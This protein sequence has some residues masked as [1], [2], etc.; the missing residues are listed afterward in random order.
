MDLCVNALFKMGRTRSLRTWFL[1]D[2]VHA[3]HRLPAI[4]HG[5]QTGR[6]FGGAFVLGMH[7]FDK[8]EETYG[9]NGATNL[10]S[11]AGTKLILKT[12]DP[13]TSRRCSEFIGDR[14]VR[15]MDEAY[16]YGYK[17]SRDAST[18]T[19]RSNVEELVMPVDISN[20]PSMHGFVKF[21]DGFPAA[22]IL[23]KWKDYPARANGFERVDDMRAEDYAPSA[24]EIAEMGGDD[25]EGGREDDQLSVA[26]EEAQIAVSVAE[27]EAA[28]LR[29][30]LEGVVDAERE[31]DGQ[32][33][34]LEA[35]GE[36][37]QGERSRAANQTGLGYVRPKRKNDGGHRKLSKRDLEE[38]AAR[39]QKSQT[40]RPGTDRSGSQE[41]ELAKENR[42][43]FGKGRKDRDDPSIDDEMDLGR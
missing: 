32:R 34:S 17:D 36:G 22:R 20:L 10:A 2:E 29:K 30:T 23:L 16:S 40:G 4:D 18:I 38:R 14:Q 39:T 28:A 31:T 19:P 37:Q 1:I 7:S 24:E 42:Q 13:E 35:D 33:L 12:A 3:L 26:P 25:R 9:A 41:S 5:L 6:G 11:L 43:G 27:R 8:L 21:P 15:I